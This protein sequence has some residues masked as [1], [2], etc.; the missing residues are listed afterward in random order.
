MNIEIKQRELKKNK[1]EIGSLQIAYLLLIRD[2]HPDIFQQ[3]KKLINFVEDYKSEE[4]KK[5]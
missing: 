1:L 4:K 5:K 3:I 2:E